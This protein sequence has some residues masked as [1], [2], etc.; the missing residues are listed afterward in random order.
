MKNIIDQHVHT[1]FSVDSKVKL[2][3]YFKVAQSLGQ[4]AICFTDHVDY[5]SLDYGGSDIA[6]DYQKIL[7]KGHR[8]ANEFGINYLVGCEI[9]YRVDL[10][11]EINNYLSDKEFDIILFSVH[12]HNEE[13]FAFSSYDDHT[14]ASKYFE[15]L[16]Q[17]LDS[18]FDFDIITH[19]D[20]VFRYLNDKESFVNYTTEYT[21][22]LKKIIKKNVAIEINTKSVMV[23]GNYEFVNFIL[24]LYYDL[25]GKHVSL[26][27][28]CHFLERYKEGFE[29][30]IE[31]MK[32]IGFETVTTFSQRQKNL[33][34]I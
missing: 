20:Y 8:L 6:F 28:D 18:N 4:K 29:E 19:I 32:V 34:K 11:D 16:N 13:H 31:I 23:I 30:I 33:V 5:D 9:G 27:S 17:M 2:E 25:G 14:T 10:E 24:K 22:I 26:G 21:Q 1:E 15:N 3:D 7:E 12:Q